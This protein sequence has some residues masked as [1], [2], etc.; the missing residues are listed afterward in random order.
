MKRLTSTA[1]INNLPA[2][3]EFIYNDRPS[4]EGAGMM[5]LSHE[6]ARYLL[7]TAIVKLK[8]MMG[9]EGWIF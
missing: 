6:N 3:L 2:V 9:A 7:H 5:N 8:K 1:S 4:R